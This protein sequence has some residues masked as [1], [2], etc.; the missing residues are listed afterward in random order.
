MSFFFAVD[1]ASIDRRTKELE[2]T[3]VQRVTNLCETYTSS[4]IYQQMVKE[5][6]VTEA[7]EDHSCAQMASQ[8]GDVNFAARFFILIGTQCR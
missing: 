5:A 3:T 1:L 2:T 4:H 8:N 7:N 6:R